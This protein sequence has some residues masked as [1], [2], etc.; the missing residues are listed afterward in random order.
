MQEVSAV[1]D[2]ILVVSD[3]K[4]RATGTELE[5]HQQTGQKNLE[6]AFVHIVT[7][8]EGHE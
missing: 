4:V 8:G 6:D 7:N 5:L 3:G 1:S 2:E